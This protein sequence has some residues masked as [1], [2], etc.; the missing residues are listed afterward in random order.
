MTKGDRVKV[1]PHG[2][3]EASA[4]GKIEIISDNQIS[5]AVS[6]GD[7]PLPFPPSGGGLAIHPEHGI[8]LLARRELLDN[9]PWGPWIEVFNGDHFE[10]EEVQ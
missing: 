8:M 5:I 1:Y 10:I 9:K 4:E 3:P 7:G 2:E 6:F